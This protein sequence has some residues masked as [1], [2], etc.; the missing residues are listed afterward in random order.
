MTPQLRFPEF[1]DEWQ[2]KKLGDIFGVLLLNAAVC[3]F[4]GD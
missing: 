3:L 4:V 1:T 2:M